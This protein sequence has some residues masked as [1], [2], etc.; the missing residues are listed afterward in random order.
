M[1]YSKGIGVN[2]FSD[3]T[4]ALGGQYKNFITDVGI[5]DSCTGTNKSNIQIVADGAIVF[6]TGAT[7]DL[8]AVVAHP[9]PEPRR[10]RQELAD[11]HRERRRR[12]HGV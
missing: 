12:R 1:S 11:A 4:Y 7:A 6:P 5:D 8:H 2:A 10:H 9:A 3:V